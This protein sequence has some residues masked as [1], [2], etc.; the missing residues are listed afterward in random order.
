M[1][2]KTKTKSVTTPRWA[3]PR[4]AEHMTEAGGATHMT[5]GGSEVVETEVETEVVAE[6]AT[7]AVAEV[8]SDQ[9]LS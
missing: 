3:A 1:N 9:E 7:E 6:E 8:V 4:G 2:L 5:E